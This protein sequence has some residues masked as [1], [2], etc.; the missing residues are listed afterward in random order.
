MV[1]VGVGV[2]SGSVIGAGAAG[3]FYCR[4]IVALVAS[5]R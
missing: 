1:V 2:G 5:S 4:T 3:G